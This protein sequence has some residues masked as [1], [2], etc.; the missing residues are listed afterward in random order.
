MGD[1]LCPIDWSSVKISASTKNAVLGNL[2]TDRA[3]TRD[4]WRVFKSFSSYKDLS[5][6]DW[7]KYNQC[8]V[9]NA[10][11]LGPGVGFGSA[12]SSIT[13]SVGFNC[14]RPYYNT[15]YSGK[16]Q[17]EVNAA[18]LSAIKPLGDHKAALFNAKIIMFEP[19]I[20]SLAEQSCQVQQ[21]R[22]TSDQVQQSLVGG[23]SV[24][25]EDDDVLES[26]AQ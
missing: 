18:V 4:Q 22:L 5:Y 6:E 14:E 3:T 17:N 8:I 15:R 7:L 16:V 23:S 12:F 20:I 24:V 26:Y 13:L 11:Q 19:E 9:F 1:Q 21:I 25:V 10:K 2:S